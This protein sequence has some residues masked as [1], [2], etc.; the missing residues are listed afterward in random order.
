M[1]ATIIEQDAVYCLARFENLCIVIWRGEPTLDR[2]IRC[3]KVFR[4]IEGS[5]GFLAFVEDGCP[6][7][8][9]A[10]RKRSAEQL[11]EFRDRVRVQAA[12]IEGDGIFVSL[13]RTAIRGIFALTRSAALIGGSLNE[14]IG[15][16]SSA[17]GMSS[18][19]LQT[20]VRSLRESYD[21]GAFA[22]K[23]AG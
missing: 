4:S 16:L 3:E 2:V 1:P 23:K 20:A 13:S 18:T 7:P 19:E 5:V 14:I 22:K 9:A 6:I 12:V 8:N 15:P 17:M 10:T 11:H 21:K